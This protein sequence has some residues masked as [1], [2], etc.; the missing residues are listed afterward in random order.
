MISEEAQHAV[1]N[2][3]VKKKLEELEK[4]VEALEKIGDVGE[5][6]V[7]P[8]K[9]QY[10]TPIPGKF[11]LTEPLV[12]EFWNNMESKKA[13]L[14]AIRV[15]KGVECKFQDNDGDTWPNC[16]FP[17]YGPDNLPPVGIPALNI[18]DNRVFNVTEQDLKCMREEDFYWNW[19]NIQYHGFPESWVSLVEES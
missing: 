10:Y 8:K 4:R 2:N 17:A 15:R 14:D 19:D 9:Q 6:K 5:L 3:I 16:R 18:G 7:E 1:Y 11:H 12:A 13:F